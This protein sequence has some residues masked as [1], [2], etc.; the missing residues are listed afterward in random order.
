MRSGPLRPPRKKPAADVEIGHRS[1][2]AAHLGNIAYRT[3]RKIRW[4]ATGETIADDLK[5]AA[6]LGRKARKPWDLI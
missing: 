5:A 1:S 4:D 6:L 2:L 3:G